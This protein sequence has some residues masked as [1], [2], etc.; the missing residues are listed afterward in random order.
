MWSDF[1]WKRNLLQVVD[2]VVLRFYDLV[3]AQCQATLRDTIARGLDPRRCRVL[4]SGFPPDETVLDDEERRDQRRSLGVEDGDVVLVNNAR[5]Y[6]EKAQDLLLRA[7]RLLQDDIPSVRLWLLGTGPL[8]ADLRRLARELSIE[9]AVRFFGFVD[10]PIPLLKLA[11]IQVHP[12]RAEGVPLA[13]CDGMAAG[14]PVVASGVGGIP[15]MITTGSNGVLVPGAL[16]PSFMASFVT[17]V[18]ALAQDAAER[19]RLGSAARRFIETDYS[20][21]AAVDALQRTYASLV[22]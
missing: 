9:T 18:A 17:V 5:F 14:L 6:P 20:L 15:E 10:Q 11:D 12:S 22:A 21:T 1:G 7:V 4:I 16:D 13:V 2:G 3:T 8:E 19:K